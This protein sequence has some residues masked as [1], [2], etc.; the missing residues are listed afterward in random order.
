[1]RTG[2]PGNA[3]I[4]L[5]VVIVMAYMVV[6]F[7]AIQF[8]YWNTLTIVLWVVFFILLR[9]RQ[10]PTALVHVADWPLWICVL[11]LA[12]GLIAP[13]DRILAIRRYH[14]F[15]VMLAILYDTDGLNS[16]VSWI[17]IGVPVGLTLA[18]DRSGI[19]AHLG[20]HF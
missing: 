8:R 14:E 12:A 13:L 18:T 6:P 20:V 10:R 4:R 11:G 7:H 17:G 5:C 9:E 3:L 1:M 2:P 16:W 19:A 15:T